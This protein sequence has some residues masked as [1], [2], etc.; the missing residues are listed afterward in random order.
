MKNVF[1]CAALLAGSMFAIA[2]EVEPTK[3]VD[4]LINEVILQEDDP[5]TYN[6][7]SKYAAAIV[8][9][10]SGGQPMSVAS[11]MYSLGFWTGACEAAGGCPCVIL[12]PVEIILE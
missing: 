8:N 2:N 11:L 9:I 7:C 4:D 3:K 1:L 12:D 6:D 5:R 10:E